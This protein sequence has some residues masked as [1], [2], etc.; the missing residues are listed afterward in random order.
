M[1]AWRSRCARSIAPKSLS[2][3]FSSWGSALG[4]VPTLDFPPVRHFL[5][6]LL[7]KCPPGLWL[8]VSSLVEHLKKHHLYFLIPAKPQFKKENETKYGR[9]GNFHESKEW[10]GHEINIAE[11][12]PDAFERVEGRY[13]ERFLEG[14]PLLLRYVDVAYEAKPVKTI[15]PLLGCLKAFRVSDRLRR[16]LEGSISEPRVTVTPNFD[17][18]VI[19]ETYPAGVLAQLAPLCEMVSQG[20]SIVL[21][22]TKQK[23]AAARAGSPDLDAAGLLRALGSGDLPANVDHELSVWSEHGEKFVLYVNSCVLETD[24]DLPAADPFTVERVAAGIRLIHSPE[25][26]FDELERQELM[27]VRIKHGNLAFTPL[28]KYASTRFPKGSSG[29][30]KPREPK[31]RVTLTRITRVLLVCPDRDLLDTLYRLLLECQCPAEID[32][33]NLTPTYSKRYESEV[34]NAIRR[35][36]TDYRLEI[37]DISS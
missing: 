24:Q 1:L 8:S 28:P 21:K 15:F 31:P 34:A 22:L 33:P 29:Q 27:P 30:E 19:A 7:A 17:V 6:G 11:S 10:W 35:L 37:D 32:R 36:K 5:L 9:C 12:D 14:I 2:C 25:K 3:G 20:S 23:I 18:H 26:L 4:V 16:A 13:V